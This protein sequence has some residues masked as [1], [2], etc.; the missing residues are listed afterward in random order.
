MNKLK[1]VRTRDD[2]WIV[3]EDYH[4]G[5]SASVPFQWES[6]PGTPKANFPE[7]GA[8]LSPLTPPPSYFSTNPN[9]PLGLN[10]SKPF[11]RAS[12]LNNVF[13]KLSMKASL[14]PRSPGSL[15]SSSSSSS[16]RERGTPGSPRRLSFDSRVDDDNGNEEENVESPVSTLSFGH[17]TDKGCYPKLAKVFTRDSK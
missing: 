16:S 14:Q 8:F 17:G 5:V 7:N 10:S 12:F 9:S 2:M 13:R 3:E 15:L 6:E 11:H 4:T 1:K